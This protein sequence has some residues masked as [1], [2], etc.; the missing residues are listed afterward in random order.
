MRG[1]AT[2]RVWLQ[3]IRPATLPAA[4]SGVVVGLGASLAAGVSFRI[5]AAAL[6]LAVAEL[7]QIAANLANDLSDYRHGADRPDRLGPVRVAAAG[8][9]T[10]RQLEAAIAVTLGAAGVAG[11]GL[12][13][14]G[15]PGVLATGAL[16]MVAL[17]AYTGGP[18]PY[19]YHALGEPFV[20]VFFGLVAVSGTAFLQAGRLEAGF[21]IASF[22]VG[23]LVTAILVVNNLRDIDADRAAGKRTLAVAL[24]PAA[25]RFEYD[26]LLLV[27]CLVPLAGAVAGARAALLLPLATTPVALRL[28]RTIH[29]PGDPRRLNRV[30]R[31]T[32]RLAL[33]FSL[34]YG[35]GLALSG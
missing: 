11:L 29:A 14:I 26:L 7:L 5:G 13:A 31:D 33:A 21:V 35:V 19:G 9:V 16:A 6:C 27:A 23:A 28:A 17:L 8:L 2:A 18:W 25:T 4:A 1:G 30:L 32:A 20:F 22:P 34:L 3:A 10:I 15:G 12:A 24:G